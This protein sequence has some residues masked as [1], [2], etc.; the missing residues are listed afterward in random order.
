MTQRAK[1]YHLFPLWFYILYIS[2]LTIVGKQIQGSTF[3][4]CAYKIII[5]LEIFMSA[6]IKDNITFIIRPKGNS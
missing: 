4:K 6:L 1:I 5:C 3:I 2:Y